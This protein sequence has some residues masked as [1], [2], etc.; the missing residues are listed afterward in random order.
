MRQVRGAM[1]SSMFAIA[2]LLVQGCAVKW[3]WGSESAKKGRRK[4]N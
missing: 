3:W 1:A 2:V 4:W